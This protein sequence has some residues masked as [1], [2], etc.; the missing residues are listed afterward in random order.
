MYHYDCAEVALTLFRSIGF[1]SYAQ[2]DFRK[3]ELAIEM[4]TRLLELNKFQPFDRIQEEIAKK[5]CRFQIREDSTK[6]NSAKENAIGYALAL[7]LDTA[8]GDSEQ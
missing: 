5:F 7:L 4:Q 3:H 6:L 8:A 2:K 1:Q